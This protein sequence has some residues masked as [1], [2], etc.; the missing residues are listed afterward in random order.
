M[1][2]GSAVVLDGA[3]GTAPRAGVVYFLAFRTGR[4][5]RAP[6]ASGC[7]LPKIHGKTETS[8][9]PMRGSKIFSRI[10]KMAAINKAQFSFGIFC[11]SL[12]FLCGCTGQSPTF[13]PVKGAVLLDGKAVPG[14]VVSF[15]SKTHEGLVASGTTDGHGVFT[16]SSPVSGKIGSGLPLGEYSVTVVK[17]DITNPPKSPGKGGAIPPGNEGGEK[18]PFVPEFV[19]HVPKMYESTETSGL[20]ATVKEKNEAMV[21]NLK[22]DEEGKGEVENE[23][24]P[25]QGAGQ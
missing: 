15:I 7:H 22:T 23:T 8:Y 10:S 12:A 19:Y 16:L 3:P 5:E 11:L 21:F 9:R 4:S 1:T 14:A 6:C 20:S 25:N 24:K 13:Y 2:A 18:P 17:K